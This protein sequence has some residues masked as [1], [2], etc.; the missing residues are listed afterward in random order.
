MNIVLVIARNNGYMRA[1]RSGYYPGKVPEFPRTRYPYRLYNH[2]YLSYPEYETHYQSPEPME[3]YSSF[4]SYAYP[5]YGEVNGYIYDYEAKLNHYQ[6]EPPGMEIPQFRGNQYPPQTPDMKPK[7]EMKNEV[8]KHDSYMEKNENE[9]MREKVSKE[10]FENIKRKMVMERKKEQRKE[11]MK[12]PM[13]KMV[14][15][16][17]K[18]ETVHILYNQ[19]KHAPVPAPPKYSEPKVIKPAA[20]PEK[21]T[22]KKE[23]QNG[24]VYYGVFKG[25]SNFHHHYQ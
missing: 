25:N 13:K 2:G 20:D 22:K 9:M 14:E 7:M 16:K 3:Y 15:N 6:V 19:G 12:T 21:P 8:K 23:P 18:A 5:G 17:E 11:Q 4:P 24:L 10:M 1:Y